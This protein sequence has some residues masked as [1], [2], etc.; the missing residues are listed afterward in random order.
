MLPGNFA[1]SPSNVEDKGLIPTRLGLHFKE[2]ENELCAGR[3]PISWS[4][5]YGV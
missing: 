2:A 4:E 5:I 1:C 3:L